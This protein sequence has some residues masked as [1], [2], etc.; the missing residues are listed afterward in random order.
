M[1]VMFKEQIKS[2]RLVIRAYHKDD[3]PKI[4]DYWRE[5]NPA[6]LAIDDGQR[7]VTKMMDVNAETRWIGIYDAD[8]NATLI[9]EIEA[10]QLA[11]V[12]GGWSISVRTRRAYNASYVT[13]ALSAVAPHFR[14]ELN[15][16]FLEA[17]FAPEMAGRQTAMDAFKKAGFGQVDKGKAPK[18]TQRYR[19]TFN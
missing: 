1:R 14:I 9:G 13:E 4:V 10:S 18:G 2:E 5:V 17:V 11:G 19:F 8:D 15:A 12:R 6:C 16:R 7:R 3:L